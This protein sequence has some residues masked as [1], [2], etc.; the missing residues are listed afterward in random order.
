MTSLMATLPE[1]VL[2]STACKPLVLLDEAI[3]VEMR[4]F[5]LERTIIREDVKCQ[6]RRP[7]TN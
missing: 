6:W 2:F 3:T 1:R 4:T 5:L 7:A